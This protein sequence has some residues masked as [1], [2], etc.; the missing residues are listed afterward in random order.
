[1]KTG[2]LAYSTVLV[3]TFIALG[4]LGACGFWSKTPEERAQWIT[5]E[6]SDELE[7]NS[8]Q[9][10]KLEQLVALVMQNRAEFYKDRQQKRDA[11]LEMVQAESFD[12]QRAVAMIRQK[13]R[14]IEEKAPET[15]R[16]YAELHNTLNREQRLNIHEQLT[17]M[18]ERYDERYK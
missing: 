4:S 18:F 1:M 10:K 6:V 3:I 17:E 2:P 11:L 7:L 16:A 14:F 5:E 8:E 13:T 9:R 15:I 12:Q